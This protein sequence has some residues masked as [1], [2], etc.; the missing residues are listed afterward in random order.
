MIFKGFAC[1]I[2]KGYQF[3]CEIV[4]SSIILYTEPFNRFLDLPKHMLNM[5]FLL[6]FAA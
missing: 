3:N 4:T 6:R 5:K 1:T 2:V